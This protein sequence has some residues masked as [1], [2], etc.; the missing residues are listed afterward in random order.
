MPHEIYYSLKPN[1]IAE[2]TKPITG[3]R[4]CYIT[5]DGLL[6]KDGEVDP[7]TL[8]AETAICGYH[9][10]LTRPRS[11]A[12]RMLNGWKP[13]PAINH[14]YDCT[15]GYRICDTTETL[16]K[17]VHWLTENT[18]FSDTITK[19]EEGI[20][21]V[22]IC[23]IEGYGTGAYRDLSDPEPRGTLRVTN[24]RLTGTVYVPREWA[25]KQIPNDLADLLSSRYPTLDVRRIDHPHT[26]PGAR[27]RRPP[28]LS[29]DVRHA[30]GRWGRYGAAH[31]LIQHGDRYLLVNPTVD[32]SYRRGRG[33][34]D[35]TGSGIWQLPGGARKTP[36]EKYLSAA[37]R[38]T[39]EESGLTVRNYD[40]RGCI[41][42]EDGDW[43]HKTY[44][45]SIPRSSPRHT[46]PGNA[47][48]VADA[49]WFTRKEVMQMKRAS[50]ID[51][52]LARE[53]STLLA[54]CE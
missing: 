13:V 10:V 4:F 15:C 20:Q 19:Q 23:N 30:T 21:G 2:F 52:D 42:T 44:V 3:W 17:Y 9:E 45:L 31:A 11:L 50:H 51:R 54:F 16:A 53:L 29:G 43:T 27:P 33:Q 6:G 41:E 14:A 40:I 38:E 32:V 39:K 46:G 49:Q 28:T 5:E 25:G 34:V 37:L 35:R 36:T 18:S 7:D 24:Y 1:Q 26:P 12:A 48:D 8:E 22:A 47:L